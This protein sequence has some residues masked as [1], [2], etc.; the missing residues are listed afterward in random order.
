M[1]PS[2]QSIYSCGRAYSSF[3]LVEKIF[4]C[5]NLK[6]LLKTGFFLFEFHKIWVT[7]GLQVSRFMGNIFID[8]RLVSMTNAITL[9][10]VVYIKAFCQL[11]WSKIVNL[12]GSSMQIND[13]FYEAGDCNSLGKSLFHSVIHRP[14]KP[15]D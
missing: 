2:T 14:M 7:F 13:H 8:I 3:A 9:E 11:G 15:N 6:A 10:L 1:R 4:T 12:L 5:L